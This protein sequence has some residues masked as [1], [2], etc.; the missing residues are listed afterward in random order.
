METKKVLAAGLVVLY[1]GAHEVAGADMPGKP[2][3]LI[4]QIVMSSTSNNAATMANMA[5]PYGSDI[6]FPPN[7]PLSKITLK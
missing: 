7:P 3:T 4:S 6:V 1:V 5:N 2:L